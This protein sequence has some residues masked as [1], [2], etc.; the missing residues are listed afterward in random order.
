[1]ENSNGTFKQL[2]IKNEVVP[3]FSSPE[4]GYFCRVMKHSLHATFAT[5]MHEQGVP[6]KVIQDRTG[7]RSL[8]AICVYEQ[9][10]T[11]QQEAAFFLVHT[12]VLTHKKYMLDII[13]IHKHNFFKNLWRNLHQAPGPV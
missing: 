4:S 11:V 12:Q 6:E 8:E 3:F 13:I 10:G 5:Q 9:T 7:H 2:H 1:M